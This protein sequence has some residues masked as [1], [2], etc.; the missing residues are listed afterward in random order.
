LP[1]VSQQGNAHQY[2]IIEAEIAATPIA[3]PG[4]AAV[5]AKLRGRLELVERDLMPTKALTQRGVLDPSPR[6]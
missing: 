3:I 2:D 6:I 4:A 5:L 1:I